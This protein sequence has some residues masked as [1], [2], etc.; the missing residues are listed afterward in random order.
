MSA[1]LIVQILE[2]LAGTLAQLTPLLE[3]GQ[4]VLSLQDASA[5]HAA[6]A[7]AEQSTAVLRPQV[8]AALDAASRV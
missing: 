2:A 1:T 3:Q 5:V 8:D 7:K 6:L 4:T